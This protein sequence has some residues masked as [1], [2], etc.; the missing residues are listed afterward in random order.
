V[1]IFV[2]AAAL[3]VIISAS[4]RHL[5]PAWLMT[6]V[7]LST[8]LGL[9]SV[10]PAL[11]ALHSRAAGLV[12]FGVSCG[13]LVSS[14]G[15]IIALYASHHVQ[16]PLFGLA[17][18]V[19]TAGLV[20]DALSV[21]LV[22]FWLARRFRF[23]V[24]LVVVL[25]GLAGVIA[26]AG[27]QADASEGWRLVAGRTLSAITSH[28][29]PFIGSGVRYFVEIF[30]I[31]L[32]AVT[33]WFRWPG[34]V[35]AALAFCLLARVSGDV[36]LCSLMLMLAALSAVRASLDPFRPSETRPEPSGRR[37]S[38]EVVPATR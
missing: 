35:G 34:G 7:G 21:A 38:L 16:A 14:V 3:P 2:C 13:S 19:A 12:L 11:R 33:L 29:D 23:A 8:A 36:P 30:A 37:A 22:A 4:S 1:A 26:W 32:G 27:I 20:L 5:A 9:A 6:L 18:G 28:P 15:R 17:R 10:L 25:A 24:L 31:L